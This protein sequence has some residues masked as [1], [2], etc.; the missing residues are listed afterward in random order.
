MNGFKGVNDTLGHAKGDLLLKCWG[1]ALNRFFRSAD[2]EHQTDWDSRNNH[3]DKDFVARYGGDE[4]LIVMPNCMPDDIPNIQERLAEDLP[5]FISEELDKYTDLSEGDRNL[6]AGVGF[7]AGT[8]T[9]ALVDLLQINPE[10]LL[11]HL[12]DK[13]DNAIYAAKQHKGKGSQFIFVSANDNV[14]TPVRRKS[15]I[16]P[17]VENQILQPHPADAGNKDEPPA[18]TLRLV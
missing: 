6:L 1:K 5:K 8:E 15:A 9:L 14:E 10:N 13:P 17:A 2:R 16:D 3:N 4:F 7:S 12:T 18:M 11:K